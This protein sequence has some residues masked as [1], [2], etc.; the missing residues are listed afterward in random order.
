MALVLTQQAE[1]TLPIEVH[2]VTPERLAGLTNKQIS[3][4]P[5]WHGRQQ[6]PLGEIF[7]VAGAIDDSLTLVWRGNLTPVH[8]I[9]AGMNRGTIRIES[10]TGRHVGS[11][12]SGGRIF[13]KG[14]VSDFLGAEMTGGQIRVTGNAGD[15]VGGNFPGSKQGMNR[16]TI[17]ID[18]DAGKGVGQAMRRGTIAIGGSAGE[19]V[20]W[21]M[22]AGTIMVFGSCGANLGAGMVRGTIVIGEP[23]TN[24][25]LPT[26]R[27]GGR[28]RVPIL[29]MISNWLSQQAFEF[30][31]TILESAL[32]QYDG[33]QLCGGRGEVFVRIE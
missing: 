15:L 18:G 31:S 28:Y 27:L 26:F 25:L 2:G 7:Q 12:M 22:R 23:G 17:L 4:L 33:D 32:Q 13:A 20:G 21:D 30:D 5:V 11:Q 6:I 29:V 8:G 9:G 1:T 10:D 19:L 3:E 16:G 24:S 14:D